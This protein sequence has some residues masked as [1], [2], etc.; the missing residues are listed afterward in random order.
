AAHGPLWPI[1]VP[2]DGTRQVAERLA[3]GDLLTL[4]NAEGAPLA[5]VA[6]EEVWEVDRA[7]KAQAVYG[8]LDRKHPGVEYLFSRPNNWAVGGRVEG[9]ELP[10]HYDYRGLRLTPAQVRAE[11]TR[12]G[13]S[14]VVPFQTRN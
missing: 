8:T 4:R 3:S 1:P 9:I 6:V 13:W 11:F 2:L 10:Q 12:R 7:A 5:A 14:R